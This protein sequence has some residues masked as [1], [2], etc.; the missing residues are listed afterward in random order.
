MLSLLEE[1]RTL[2]TDVP[3]AWIDWVNRDVPYVNHLVQHAYI[4][5]IESTAYWMFL[6]IGTV[7]VVL[8]VILMFTLVN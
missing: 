3:K 6:R 1:I 8:S 4:K 5:D 7:D 2:V